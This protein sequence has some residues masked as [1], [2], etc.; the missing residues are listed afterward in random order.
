LIQND[1]TTS[2][3]FVFVI[4]ARDYPAI[5]YLWQCCELR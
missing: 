5:N 2:T 3:S 1:L 4:V